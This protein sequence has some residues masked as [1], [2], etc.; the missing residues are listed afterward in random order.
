MFDLIYHK[1]V[2]T[3]DLQRLLPADRFVSRVWQTLGTELHFRLVTYPFKD[4][5]EFSRLYPVEALLIWVSERDGLDPE[6]LATSDG[7]YYD[8]QGEEI[9]RTILPE[10]SRAEQLAAYG[11]WL[12]TT[13]FD[14][15]GPLVGAGLNQ[16]GWDS[17]EVVEHKANCLLL[18]YQALTYARDLA[19]GVQL[20]AEQIQKA[21]TL[22][23]SRLG[24]AGAKKRHA[25]MAALR[26][27]AVSLYKEGSWPSPNK[28]A[29]ALKDQILSHGRVIGASLSEENAQR[30]IAEWF[31]KSV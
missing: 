11:L 24:K 30:T 12:A 13:E 3:V 21:A 28:A 19:A 8:D 15:K 7:I 22:D 29:H 23:F 5:I 20:N 2:V 17:Q 1:R 4:E 25:P 6:W 31:R 26:N 10:Y 14:S 18:A 27:W 16:Q 9:S